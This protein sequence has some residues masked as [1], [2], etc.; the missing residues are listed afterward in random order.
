[1]VLHA[2]FMLSTSS[3]SVFIQLTQHWNLE[4][5]D[6]NASSISLQQL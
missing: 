2:S 5:Q 1:M 3:G 6:I 4:L